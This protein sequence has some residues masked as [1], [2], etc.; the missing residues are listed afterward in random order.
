[1]TERARAAESR[2]H[3]TRTAIVVAAPAEL[4]A[5]T[6]LVLK[7]KVSCSLSCDLRGSA[8]RIVD[9]DDTVAKEAEF[10]AYDGTASETDEFLVRAPTVPGKYTWRAV[11]AV[12][13]RE[14]VL[15][16]ESSAEFSFVAKPHATSMVVWDVPSPVALGARF[17][18]RVGARC[19]AQCRLT[20]QEI[21]LYDQSG[22]K[23]AAGILSEAPWAGTTALYWA[24]MEPEAPAME[25]LYTWQVNFPKPNLEPAH[26]GTCCTFTFATAR[27]PEHVVVVEVIDKNTKA[28]NKDAHVTLHAPGGYPYRGRTD[29][30]GVA[31]LSVP[32]GNYEL[33]VLMNDYRD[34]RT[35]VEVVSDV[36]VK[37]EMTYWPPYFQ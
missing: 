3:E 24:E 33:S 26:E 8:I 14:G 21:E 15:H 1:M 18:V 22:A 5:G 16:E 17:R 6:D 29:V 7:A 35:T 25:G 12:R 36:T 27:P 9:Q 31:R 23:L 19:S 2:V 10:V 32:K 4:D 37:V 13:E 34:L 30:D 11:L 20:A 28:P